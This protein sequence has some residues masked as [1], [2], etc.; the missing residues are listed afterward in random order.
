MVIL[1]PLGMSDMIRRDVAQSN[2]AHQILQWQ[3]DRQWRKAWPRDSMSM[4][5]RMTEWDTKLLSYGELFEE[6]MM[7]L[8]VNIPLEKAL[9]KGWEI[10]ASCFTREETGLRTELLKKF[11]PEG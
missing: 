1:L 10:L 11:W 8:T 3:W 9:D 4:G 7:N 5:F 2:A 6:E